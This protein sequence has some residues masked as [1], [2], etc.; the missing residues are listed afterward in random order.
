MTNT[1]DI[2]KKLVGGNIKAARAE[3]GM[4]QSA[5]SQK[6]EIS[7]TQLSDYENGNKLPGLNSI[8]K[9]AMA[10]GKSIDELCYGD[11]SMSP[12]TTAPDKGSVIVNCFVAL[13]E[14]GAIDTVG[15]KN[16]SKSGYDGIKLRNH[17]NGIKR[18]MDNL[19][20]FGIRRNTYS[21]PKGYLEY[22]KQSIA[23]EINQEEERWER[24]RQFR[25]KHGL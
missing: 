2:D 8:A 23:S 9:I 6:A 16:G 1:V 19:Y 3:K 18:L 4:T 22:V 20:E 12:I 24:D 21:D 25:E 13:W 14:Q 11:A 15:S 7:Q 5:L 17:A 10:L